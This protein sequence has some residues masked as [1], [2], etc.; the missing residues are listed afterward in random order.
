MT[1][2][3]IPL[4]MVTESKEDHLTSML[5]H[6]CNHYPD[7]CD[8]FSVGILFVLETK[9]GMKVMVSQ[10]VIMDKV[11]ELYLALVPEEVFALAE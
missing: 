8:S 6:G 7:G 1:T 10:G 9:E 11:G 3:Y 2:Q 5:T 4:G